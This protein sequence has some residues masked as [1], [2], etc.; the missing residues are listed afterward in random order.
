MSVIRTVASHEVVRSLFPRP[1]VEGQ[2]IGLAAGK[3]VDGALS[4]YSHEYRQGRRPGVQAMAAFAAEIFDEEIAAQG[5]EVSKADREKALAPVPQVIKAFRQSVLFGLPRP[6]SRLILINGRA[7]VYAQPDFWDGR[8]RIYEMKSYKAVP[9][10]PDVALQLRLFQLAFPNLAQSLVCIDRH[11]EPVVTLVE[12]IARP[13]TEEADATL[14][15]AL[16]VALRTGTDKVYE[17]VDNPM[18]PYT[19]V[20]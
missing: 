19:V 12:E 14:R 10:R 11:A 18:T 15:A 17:Y 13:T 1:V 7:G 16:D 20:A 4:R 8:T 5:A 2:E 6:K 9:L 3:A